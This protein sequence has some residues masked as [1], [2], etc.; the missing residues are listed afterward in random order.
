[1]PYIAVA[2]VDASAKKC[3]SLGGSIGVPPTDIPKVGR[4]AV[5]RDPQ[6]ASFS[7][8]KGMPESPG[9]DPDLP[10]PGRVCWNELLTT[11]DKAAQKFY[12]AMFGWKEQ[13]KDM[14]QIGT[15]HIQVLGDKHAGGIMKNPQNGAPSAWLSYF[16]VDDLAKA[17]TRAKKLTA[18]A[19]L[20]NT[21]IPEIGSFSMLTDPVGATFALFQASP[22]Q[23]S[24]TGKK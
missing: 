9:F 2:D 13:T 6:R 19:L 18:K 10:V 14:G 23:G 21:P 15:Y 20:E 16:L 8:F 17:T 3:T 1:M 24:K 11:D 12:S 7:L 4:F 22:Q 5:V